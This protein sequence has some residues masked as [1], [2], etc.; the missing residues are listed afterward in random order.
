[1]TYSRSLVTFA[2]VQ[3]ALEKGDIVTGLFPLFAPAIKKNQGKP[4]DPAVFA[5]D[6]NEVCGLKVHPFIVEDWAPRMAQHNLLVA[7]E[8]EAVAGKK[9]IAYTNADP[10]I[11]DVQGLEDKITGFF[12][13]FE[14]FVT[15]LFA[16]NEISVPNREVLERE[17]VDRI[18]SMA[19][20][21]ILSKP[22][23]ILPAKSTLTLDKS[24]ALP[25]PQQKVA[26]MLDVVCAS[27]FLKLRNQDAEQFEL[28]TDLAGGA[29]GAEVLST[30]RVPPKTGA[31]FHGMRI[32]L[33]SPLILDLLDV[34]SDEDRQFARY[35]L[36]SL[37]LEGATV[38]TFDHNVGE[39]VDVLTASNN[40]FERKQ[41]VLGHVGARLR[42][43]PRT[44]LRVKGVLANPAKRVRDLGI[45][46]TVADAIDR[47]YSSGVGR[48]Y[49][50]DLIVKIEGAACTMTVSV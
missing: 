20:D 35:L 46:I 41:E 32:Y 47:P 28:V 42:V 40:N 25:T 34:G 43:D 15:P 23:R 24:P 18:R 7:R 39:I 44:M 19:F 4:F 38:A 6:L 31:S 36:E 10:D 2:F 5:A 3:E 33:D 49:A 11:P 37:K 48:L 17:L 26:Q 29:L 14:K 45:D 21:D 8:V 16:E 27:F 50:E 13:A 22:D 12:D 30:F 9:Y 1:M